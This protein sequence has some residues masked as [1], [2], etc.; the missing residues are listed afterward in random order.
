MFLVQENS[1]SGMCSDAGIDDK[2]ESATI[3]KL[4]RI[5]LHSSSMQ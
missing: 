2:C 4:V 3:S 1:D 5:H